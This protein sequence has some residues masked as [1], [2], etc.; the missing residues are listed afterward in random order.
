[1]KLM[2]YRMQGL[3]LSGSHTVRSIVVNFL[4]QVVEK[5]HG[6]SNVATCVLDE[7]SKDFTQIFSLFNVSKD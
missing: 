3:I 5:M 6:K 1:M 7:V 2:P 4:N